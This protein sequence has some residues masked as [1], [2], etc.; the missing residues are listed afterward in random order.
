M[1]NRMKVFKAIQCMAI[2]AFS[3]IIG[4]SITGCPGDPE[5]PYTSPTISALTGTVTIDNTAPK[6]NDILIATYNPGNGSG[7]TTWV[8]LADS[9]E[10]GGAT[11]N[12]YTV[13]AGDLDKQIVAQVSFAKQ[14]GN[15]SSDATKAVVPA[16]L[17]TLNGTVTIDNT[18]PKVGDILIATYNP[19]NGSG[20]ATWVWLADSVEIGGANTNT[21][22]VLA[23]DLDKQLVARVSYADQSGNISSDATTAVEEAEFYTEGLVFTLEAD[24]TY[25]VSKG[26]ATAAAVVIPS[27]YN[28]RP[29]RTISNEGF[30][31]Y[32]DMTSITIPNTITNIGNYAFYG[33]WRLTNIT[34]PGSVTNIGRN[35]FWFCKNLINIILPEGVI[36]IG[37]S[38][39]YDCQN[40]KSIT[41]PVSVK[42][43]DSNILWITNNL[44]LVFYGGNSSDWGLIDIDY[45]ND[46]LLNADRYY[47]SETMP[48]EAGN[49]WRFV[50]GVPTVWE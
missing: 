7:A 31:N 3:V 38:A 33:N 15:I 28:G 39:F 8:W 18:N 6:V 48:G 22:T 45:G 35:A 49:F 16:T 20:A 41:I 17:P 10:I 44:E 25:S 5:D 47:Y 43:I 13:L 23:D 27:S 36:S 12:T 26:T 32:Y 11:T 50:A 40:L 42:N 29:V 21:Y 2:I 4:F 9:V 24:N 19:G 1:K 30:S 37:Q 34:I 14:S 46:D